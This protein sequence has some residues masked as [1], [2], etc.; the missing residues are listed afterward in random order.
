[1]IPGITANPNEEAAIW[2][3][4]SSWADHF[5]AAFGARGI[6]FLIQSYEQLVRSLETQTCAHSADYASCCG[7]FYEFTNDLSVRDAVQ[8]VLDAVCEAERGR[9]GARVAPID[10]RY[11]RQQVGSEFFLGKGAE[12]RYGQTKYWWY[13][14]LPRGVRP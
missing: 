11:R 1:M 12:A 14:G 6:D 2:D 10:E 3:G 7:D 8:I 4:F 5:R 9:I 13:Y